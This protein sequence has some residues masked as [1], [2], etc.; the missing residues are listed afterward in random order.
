MLRDL[1]QQEEMPVELRELVKISVKAYGKVVERSVGRVLYQK[2]EDIRKEMADLR[3]KNNAET[4]VVLGRVFSHLKSMKKTERR[5]VSRAYTLMLELMNTC[6][7]AYRSYRLSQSLLKS[8][9]QNESLGMETPAAVEPQQNPTTGPQTIIYVLT[10]HPTEARS[11]ENIAAFHLIQ[12]QLIAA[13]ESQ[14]LKTLENVLDHSLELAWRTSIVRNR[15]PSVMD[16]AAHIYSTLLARTTLDSL[17]EASHTIA[18]LYIRSWVGGDKDGHPG[19]DEKVMHESLSLSR[20]YLINNVY[21]YLSEVQKTLSNLGLEVL[22]KE[23]SLLIKSLRRFQLVKSEDGLRI[24]KLRQ[25]IQQMIQRYKKEFHFLHPNLIQLQRLLHVF[26]AL[27]VPLELR[28]SSDVLMSDQRQ[29]SSLAIDRMLRLLANLS[30]GGS[31]KWYVRGFIISMASS[32]EHLQVAAKKM[33]FA[34][35]KAKIPVIPLFEQAEALQKASVIIQEWVQNPRVRR[36]MKEEWG[37]YCE[38][39]VGYSDSAKESGVLFS[40]LEIAQAMHQLDKL[41]LEEKVQPLFFQGSG[42]SVDRGGGSIQDQIAWWPRSALLNYKVTIQGEIVERSLA[43]PE[44]ARGQIERIAK[45]VRHTM[46]QSPSSPHLEVLKEFAASVAN[47]YKTMIQD[48]VFLELVEYS[49]PYSHLNELHIG[50]RPSSRSQRLV[51]SGLRA[52]PWV[53]CWTQTRVLFPTWWGIGSSWKSS[54][55]NVRENLKKVFDSEPVFA[56][57]VRALG[58]TLAKVELSVWR[59]YLEQSGIN[60]KVIENIFYLF[61]QEFQQAVEMVQFISGDKNPLWFHHRLGASIRLR[62]PMIHPLN[63]LQ[64]LAI[65]EKD[66]ILL[67]LTVTGIS[68]GMLT[69]G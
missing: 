22:Q 35:G 13:L 36:E 42:G 64:I 27:L 16:E 30:K 37:N 38:I 62:S 60:P 5:V 50:S 12:R 21:L 59:I 54:S 6:E 17:L 9:K 61:E 57:Y 8:S 41:C 53:M 44:I 31:P 11:P 43:S 29:R 67:R 58:F 32:I 51:V 18:P 68:S 66:P 3:D 40:R 55:Y 4:T 46:N 48:P 52:I 24:K 20:R 26:P 47:T 28:E 69:T 65:Q 34:L 45:S 19:V 33:R 23:F 7:N 56:S 1:P 49:T 15:A 63:L 25:Q 14:T 2:I 39:M 10:A